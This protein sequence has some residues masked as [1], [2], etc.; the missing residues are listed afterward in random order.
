VGAHVV[1]LEADRR[2]E[3]R[4]GLGMT[5]LP[6]EGDAE[7]TMQGR[8]LRRL[9]ERLPVGRLGVGVAALP[10]ETESHVG[11]RADVIGLD[12]DRLS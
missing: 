9:L 3:S 10:A 2:F 5:A 7:S 1:R 6:V 4:L 8:V 12:A 11:P